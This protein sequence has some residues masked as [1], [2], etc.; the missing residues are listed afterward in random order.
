[1]NNSI[2]LTAGI[3]V[4]ALVIGYYAMRKLKQ[5]K[6]MVASMPLAWRPVTTTEKLKHLVK[7]GDQLRVRRIAQSRIQHD[8]EVQSLVV[9]PECAVDFIKNERHFCLHNKHA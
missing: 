3:I 8:F 2:I 7:H 5:E 1:M 6:I 4:F 9:V